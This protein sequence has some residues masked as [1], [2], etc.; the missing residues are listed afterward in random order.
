MN[1]QEMI[2]FQIPRAGMIFKMRLITHKVH[3]FSVF[4]EIFSGLILNEDSHSVLKHEVGKPAPLNR[5]G[6]EV[7]LHAKRTVTGVFTS[8]DC[9]IT[10]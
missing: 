4:L 8:F 10:F 5:L 7:L 1:D 9:T 6:V 3:T 2:F